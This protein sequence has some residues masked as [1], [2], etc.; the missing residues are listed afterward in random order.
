MN[1]KRVKTHVVLTSEQ[2]LH[3]MYCLLLI[4]T[5]L[6]T[7]SK[8]WVLLSIHKYICLWPLFHANLGE[9]Y[10]NNVSVAFPRLN[11]FINTKLLGDLEGYKACEFGR[12]SSAS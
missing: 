5:H 11:V 8:H 10:H 1:I 3:S 4:S 9:R 7:C 12:L 6:N 2:E